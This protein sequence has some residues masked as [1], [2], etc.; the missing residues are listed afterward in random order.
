MKTLQIIKTAVIGL[1]LGA[2]LIGSGIAEASTYT[3]PAVTTTSAVSTLTGYFWVDSLPIESNDKYE[4]E[5]NIYTVFAL[6]PVGGVHQFQTLKLKLKGNYSQMDI[7]NISSTDPA[8][9]VA[10][11]DKYL[12][13]ATKLTP[14]I[15]RAWK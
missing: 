9:K 14:E 10:T 3:K 7:I 12:M 1:S 2:L 13:P 4:Q 5:N 15:Q 11:G 6:K 8:F